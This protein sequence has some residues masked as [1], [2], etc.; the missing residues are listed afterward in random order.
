M[1]GRRV[2]RDMQSAASVV[3]HARPEGGSTPKEAR[4][5]GALVL[6]ISKHCTHHPRIA[7]S[8]HVPIDCVSAVCTAASRFHYGFAITH[9]RRYAAQGALLLP[10]ALRIAPV[11]ILHRLECANAERIHVLD[12]RN[13]RADLPRDLQRFA[14][15]RTPQSH[16]R[17][18]LSRNALQVNSRDHT[19][20]TGE[21]R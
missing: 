5:F 2:H 7:F 17:Q 3:S 21:W 13:V 18:H 1:Y 12:R 10:A 6:S 11:S 15:A 20:R 8:S 14:S 9:G 16:G 4:L 19:T